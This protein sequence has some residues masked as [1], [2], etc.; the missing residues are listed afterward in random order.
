MLIP[1]GMG[2]RVVLPLCGSIVVEVDSFLFLLACLT[3][4]SKKGNKLLHSLKDLM[5]KS[6]YWTHYPY[7]ENCILKDTIFRYILAENENY[8]ACTFLHKWKL[9]HLF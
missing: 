8:F 5:W 7:T 1:G 6:Y 3:S 4:P 2:L 9:F